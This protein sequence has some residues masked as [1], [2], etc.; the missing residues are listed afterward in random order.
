MPSTKGPLASPGEP[1]VL[2][3]VASNRHANRHALDLARE[4]CQ[5][6][7]TDRRIGLVWAARALG[8]SVNLLKSE[9]NRS[10][11]D[12]TVTALGTTVSYD[13]L[14]QYGSAHGVQVEARLAKLRRR[15][16]KPR[17]QRMT[18]LEAQRIVGSEHGDRFGLREAI[19]QASF[20]EYRGR[21]PVRM[22]AHQTF[23]RLIKQSSI[24]DPQT[25][26][27][28]ADLLELKDRD[29]AWCHVKSGRIETEPRNVKKVRLNIES[30][31]FFVARFHPDK[32][33]LVYSAAK[34][35]RAFA[36]EPGLRE[37][38]AQRV[39]IV[40]AILR[41]YYCYT[42]AQVKERLKKTDL[43]VLPTSTRNRLGAIPGFI[44]NSISRGRFCA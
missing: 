26:S 5:V 6:P 11:L 17:G 2:E 15:N 14:L 33:Q 7:I 19:A 31:L 35:H 9:H 24:G 42:E 22:L 12:L 13:R 36:Q 39:S 23:E 29:T 44:P 40:R 27:G 21:K 4:D 34:T 43:E 10:A 25:L 1:L 3:L 28:L 8:C 16:I 30:V 38:W 32:L 18:L 41:G 20:V 37:E